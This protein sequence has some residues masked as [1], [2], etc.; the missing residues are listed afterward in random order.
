MTR[1]TGICV[2]PVPLVRPE[3][4]PEEQEKINPSIALHTFPLDILSKPCVFSSFRIDF[5][6][7]CFANTSAAFEDTRTAELATKRTRKMDGIRRNGTPIAASRGWTA[8]RRKTAIFPPTKCQ[9]PHKTPKSQHQD[10]V[11]THRP[12]P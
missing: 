6:I 12:K 11:V 4:K 7:I 9:S 1:N 3:F 10:V 8:Q 2:W 5:Y